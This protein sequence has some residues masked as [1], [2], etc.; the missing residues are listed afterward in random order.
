MKRPALIFLSALLLYGS[1]TMRA[2][3][4]E[5]ERKPPLLSCSTTLEATP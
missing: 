2:G 3:T 4:D 5:G 1:G